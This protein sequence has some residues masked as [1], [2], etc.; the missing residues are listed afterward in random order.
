MKKSGFL[1]ITLVLIL[2]SA[3]N[4]EAGRGGTS[5]IL[6]KVHVYDINGIGDTIAE[7]DAMDEDVFIIY[8]ENDD[9]YD[10]KFSC[11][12]DGTYRFDYLNTGTYTLYA[13]S[14]CDT[15]NDGVQPIFKTV[16]ITEKKTEYTAPTINILK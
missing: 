5:S 13:Y 3:C 7:Y 10:D 8:G 11:S 4:K 16:E 9:T 6:G 15:C 1:L 2:A 12:F 14:R